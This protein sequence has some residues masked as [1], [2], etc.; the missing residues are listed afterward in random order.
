MNFIR[1]ELQS[2]YRAKAI[3]IVVRIVVMSIVVMAVNSFFQLLFNLK[4]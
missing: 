4:A 3:P 2:R 1:H